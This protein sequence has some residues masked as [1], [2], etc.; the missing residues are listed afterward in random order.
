MKKKELALSRYGISSGNLPAQCV[1]GR[2]PRDDFVVTRQHFLAGYSI[3]QERNRFFLSFEVFQ[4]NDIPFRG[5]VFVTPYCERPQDRIKILPALGQ[6]VF[7][8][9]RPVAIAMP[10]KYTGIHQSF[11]TAGQRV[12][13]YIREALLKFIELLCAVERF[14]N[15]KNAPPFTD[16]VETKGDRAYHAFKALMFHPALPFVIVDFAHKCGDVT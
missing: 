4:G 13:G 8:A 7:V 2:R 3:S 16:S 6:D 15:D 11:Q 14:P 12:G 9:G 5:E 10:F 1:I